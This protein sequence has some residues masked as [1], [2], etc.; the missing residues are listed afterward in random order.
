MRSLSDGIYHQ[1]CHADWS[2]EALSGV[3]HAPEDQAAE[4][5]CLRLN[6][7]QIPD[8]HNSFRLRTE[9]RID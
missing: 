7:F 1:P 6:I 9:D 8:T 2:A 5:G 4:I 3:C